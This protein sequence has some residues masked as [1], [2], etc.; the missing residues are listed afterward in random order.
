MVARVLVGVVLGLVGAA[1][2]AVVLA[3]S[4][5]RG[6][7][8]PG[9][10]S[11]LACVIVSAAVILIGAALVRRADPAAFVPV[12]VTAALAM[13]VAVTIAALVAWRRLP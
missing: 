2:F 7:R 13:L 11:G 5:A 9:V 1:P 12:A 6:S 8:G 3:R 4:V 10:R